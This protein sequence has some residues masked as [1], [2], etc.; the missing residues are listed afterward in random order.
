MQESTLALPYKCESL[1]PDGLTPYV[2]SGRFKRF[3]NVTAA[4]VNQI[5]SEN[6]PSGS[7]NLAGVLQDA[8]D[9]HFQGKSKGEAAA[10]ET[11][12]SDHRRGTRRSPGGVRGDRAGCEADGIGRGTSPFLYPDR[13]G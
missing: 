13:Q 8:L 2:F 3:D 4:K 10:G 11:I 12:V 5:C 6:E 9:R 7:T 1:Y